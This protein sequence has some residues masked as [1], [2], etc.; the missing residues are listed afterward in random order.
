MA[1]LMPLL[2]LPPLTPNQIGERVKVPVRTEDPDVL[3]LAQDMMNVYEG[4]VPIGS[5]SSEYQEKI[6]NF[7]RFSACRPMSNDGTI[8]KRTPDTLDLV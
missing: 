7:Y 8:A 6:R 4:R 3:Q 2:S 1:S 5:F